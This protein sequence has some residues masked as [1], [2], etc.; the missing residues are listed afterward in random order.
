MEHTNEWGQSDARFCWKAD[1]DW[2]VA[3]WRWCDFVIWTHHCLYRS[4]RVGTGFSRHLGL[5]EGIR[6]WCHM[7]GYIQ[8]GDFP[9]QMCDRLVGR[10][11]PS[12]NTVS[13]FSYCGF[14]HLVLMERQ[15]LPMPLCPMWYHS[16]CWQWFI[17]WTQI[18]QIGTRNITCRGYS[19][20]LVGV[21]LLRKLYFHH[22]WRSCVSRFWL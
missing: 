16:Y 9:L 10:T 14:W 15:V 11:T 8:Y 2:S 3:L 5:T 17:T 4:G 13:C 18:N 21:R 22:V 7:Y 6:G 12:R 1:H 19:N 20:V